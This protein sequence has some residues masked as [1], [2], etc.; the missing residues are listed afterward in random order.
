MTRCRRSSRRTPVFLCSA[1]DTSAATT[2]LSAL[3]SRRGSQVVRSRSE[4]PFRSYVEK[5]RCQSVAAFSGK[6]ARA[7]VPSELGIPCATSARRHV[8]ECEHGAIT[9]LHRTFETHWP[10]GENSADTHPPR[11]KITPFFRLCSVADSSTDENTVNDC[12]SAFLLPHFFP[13]DK[14]EN[15]PAQFLAVCWMVHVE[16]KAHHPSR[17]GRP[18]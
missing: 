7:K 14:I 1:L 18:I 4:K 12:G 11:R 9:R 17:H 16:F 15:C 5:S 8:V 6:L 13:G 2:I 3:A 10:S